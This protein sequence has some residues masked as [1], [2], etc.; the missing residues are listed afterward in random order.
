MATYGLEKKD[1]KELKEITDEIVSLIINNGKLHIDKIILYGSYARGTADDESDIDIMI[2]CND[3][4]KDV[5]ENKRDL[6]RM[7]D[8]VGYEHDILVQT[9][10]E[11]R[12]FFEHWVDDMPFFRNVRD[13]GVVLYE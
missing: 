1:D 5:S 9:T 6:W 10:F 13:E 4:R 8:K 2:L 12:G 11:E 3:S 7:A